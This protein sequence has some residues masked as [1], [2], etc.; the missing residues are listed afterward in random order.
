VNVAEL[1][2]A[3][4]VMPMAADVL[5]DADWI[6]VHVEELE[7]RYKTYYIDGKIVTTDKQE[8]VLS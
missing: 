7:L 2:E 6:D 5:F 3:L 1:I 4:K 8:V